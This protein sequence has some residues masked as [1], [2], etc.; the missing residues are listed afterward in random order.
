MTRTVVIIA[1]IVVVAVVGFVAL[2]A[3]LPSAPRSPIATSAP[4]PKKFDTTGGQEMLP[5]WQ[6]QEGEGDEAEN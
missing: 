4:V 2:Q 3:V 5:R 6:R 1:G